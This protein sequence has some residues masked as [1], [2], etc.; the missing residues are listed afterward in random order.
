MLKIDIYIGINAHVTMR[1][2]KTN[3]WRQ[4][5]SAF[6]LEGWVLQKIE[7][8]PNLVESCLTCAGLTMPSTTSGRLLCPI[9]SWIEFL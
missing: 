9:A 8:P 7:D 2:G 5:Y 6:E 4:S 3:N 1:D